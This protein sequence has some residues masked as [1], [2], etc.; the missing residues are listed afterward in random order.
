[1]DSLTRAYQEIELHRRTFGTLKKCEFHMHSPA[2]YDYRM[3]GTAFCEVSLTDVIDIALKEGWISSA[4]RDDYHSRVDYFSSETFVKDMTDRGEPYS[5]LKEKLAY[6]IIAF[7]LYKEGIEVAVI[8]DH[9]TVDGY[10][11]LNYAIVKCYRERFREGTE[12][13][14]V[15]LLLGV[16]ISCSEENHLICIFEESNYNAVKAYLDEIIHSTQGGT[17]HT[18]HYVI[19]EV[20]TKFN[21]IAYLAHMNT[22]N[23]RGTGVYYEKLCSSK[24]AR[25][26][27]LTNLDRESWIRNTINAYVDGA[28][29]SICV[30]HEGDSHDIS[31]IG[32]RNTWIKFSNKPS[33]AS[34]MQAFNN[35]EISVYTRRPDATPVYIKG[36]VV[37]AGDHGFLNVR[38]DEPKSGSF[39]VDFSSD[40]NCIIG[41]RGTGKST[42][43]NVLESVLSQDILDVDKLKFVCRHKLIHVVLH[44]HGHDYI[45]RFIPQTESFDSQ[46]NSNAS[47]LPKAFIDNQQTLSDAWTQLFRI[48]GNDTIEIKAKEKTRILNL[49]YRRG[50]SIN[51]LLHKVDSGTIG[52]FIRDT[53]LFG[54]DD[55]ETNQLLAKIGRTRAGLNVLL[56]NSLSKVIDALQR[57]K[58]LVEELIAPF[59]NACRDQ[60]RIDYSQGNP[61]TNEFL[62]DIFKHNMRGSGPISG[63]ILRW[64]DI[65]AYL[66][67]SVSKIGYLEFLN[68]LLNDKFSEI[69]A[70]VSLRS[71]LTDKRPSV[72]DINSSL[73]RDVNDYQL[74][75]L[76]QTIR[77]QFCKDY[78]LLK[79]SIVKW[80]T[81][82]DD[83]ALNFNINSRESSTQLKPQMK[84][85]HELSLGQQVVAI[86]TFVFRYGNYT[87]DQTPL[88]IDQP[89]DNLDNQY[90]YKNLVQSLREIKNN[91]QVIV[92]THSSTIVTNADAEQVIVM[93]SDG[94]K[95]WIEKTGYP[96]NKSVINHIINYLEGGQDSF[97]HKMKT[98][99]FHIKALQH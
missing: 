90:V 11:L 69:E 40:L 19:E 78:I 33:F 47:F 58:T 5:S 38:N 77:K 71:V 91:R 36:I 31:S 7:R 57:R 53:I 64:G 12:V 8:C 79:D 20:S 85:L 17:Y 66:N 14:C 82:F 42:L 22:S 89:E 32:K 35:H 65:E 15:R 41:G 10:P 98:Y 86:L 99:S 13:Q 1:M 60:L 81:E 28:G 73:L 54:V 24:H 88:V 26:I 72:K 51:N 74:T 45:V 16:E 43:L 92:V 34:L 9:N 93:N 70:K 4:T 2:S 3:H 76:Y 95:G 75:E 87:G 63:T 83:F 84:P 52:S 25:V 27:G 80:F 97:R 30:L 56:K 39:K 68:L 62:N 50:Y 67:T 21:G 55:I 49:V 48:R 37:D 29:S 59:N 23:F 61:G 46:Y 94:L 44:C 6:E 18:S 96:S